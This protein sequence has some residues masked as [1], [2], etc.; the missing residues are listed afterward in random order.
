[1]ASTFLGGRYEEAWGEVA[2]DPSNNIVV[3]GASESDNYPSTPGA[4]EELFHGPP[5]PGSHLHDVV[6]SK[7]S[8]DLDSLLAST[9]IGTDLFDGGQLMTLDSAGNVIIGGHTESIEYPVTPG[10]VDEVHNGQNEYFLT[11]INN[12]L[13]TILA[14]T[15]LTPE[16]GGWTYL[17]DL[18]TDEEGN[19]YGVGAAWESDCPT[20]SNAFDTTFNGGANDFTLLQ[21]SGD[22]TTLKYATFLGG[23]LDEGDC[24]VA[25]DSVGIVFVAGYTMSPDMPVRP[26]AFDEIFNGGNRDAFVAAMKLESSSVPVYLAD[27]DFRVG[28]DTVDFVWRVGRD[29]AVH[30]FRMTALSGAVLRDLPIFS[31]SSR[32]FQAKDT[33]LAGGTGTEILYRLYSRE[34]N[35]P[36]MLLRTES[37]KKKVPEPGVRLR[38]VYPSPASRETSVSFDV[39]SAARLEIEVYGVNGRRTARV[40]DRV[41]PIGSHTAVWDGRDE[42][43][44][45]AASG[46]YFFR[47]SGNRKTQIRKFTLIR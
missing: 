45:K 37:V 3:G 1:M 32:R 38:S 12:D 34:G 35:E 47:I 23:A 42:R 46:V 28:E 6:V 2:V 26:G 22:L 44:R 15:F 25:V 5:Q 8:N 14:S 10:A 41:F 9:F 4:Y 43:G 7:L 30:N 24:A 11:S 27:F 39:G 33:Q 16:D 31:V 17:T 19:I 13:T 40:A 20:T 21:F 29:A 18:G 36:W